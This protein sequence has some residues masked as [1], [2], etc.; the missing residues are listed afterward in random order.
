MR[1]VTVDKFI[2]FYTVDTRSLTVTVI[3]I[4]YGGQDIANI[5][6]DFENL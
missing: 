6:G 4:F 1:K 5:A 2:A 3:R